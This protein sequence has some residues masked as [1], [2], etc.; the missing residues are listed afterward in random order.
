VGDRTAWL[1]KRG[2]V[3]DVEEREQNESTCKFLAAATMFRVGL[4][5]PPADVPEKT[6]LDGG[7]SLLRSHSYIAIYASL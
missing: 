7:T 5:L 1:G 3:T 6:I 2:V 4:D